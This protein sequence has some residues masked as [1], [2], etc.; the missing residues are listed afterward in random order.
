MVDLEPLDADDWQMVRHMIARHIQFTKSAYAKNMQ[1]TLADQPF[2][3]VMPRDYKR[4]K[5]AEA[6]ARAENREPAFAELVGTV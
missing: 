6:K 3:K 5:R 1:A 4:V 2:L